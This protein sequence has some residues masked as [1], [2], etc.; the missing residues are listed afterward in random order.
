MTFRVG[1]VGTGAISKFHVQGLRRL[2]DVEIVGVTD[3]P[4][5]TD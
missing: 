2:A 3:L 5:S 4:L 1:L